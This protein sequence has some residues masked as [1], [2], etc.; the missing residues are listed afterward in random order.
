MVD[1]GDVAKFIFCLGGLNPLC[2][3]DCTSNDENRS[4]QPLLP[5]DS[6]YDS[7]EGVAEVIDS[8]TGYS[9]DVPRLDAD[10]ADTFISDSS[11]AYEVIDVGPK[12]DE[13]SAPDAVV[14]EDTY[15]PPQPP[16][17]YTCRVNAEDAMGV[18]FGAYLMSYEDVTETSNGWAGG[19]TIAFSEGTNLE[20][21]NIE[22]IAI[23]KA[24]SWG[25]GFVESLPPT[26]ADDLVAEYS[27]AFSEGSPGFLSIENFNAAGENST[28]TL[29]PMTFANKYS[30]EPQPMSSDLSNVVYIATNPDLYEI[31][32]GQGAG[33]YN[34]NGA[35][36]YGDNGW[37]ETVAG[38]DNVMSIEVY[39]Y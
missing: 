19:M 36:Y 38:W 31:P 3:P 17:T 27:V 32:S 12:P 25:E 22:T 24:D 1:A 10:V 4:F 15:Q 18:V 20:A 2:W 5:T 28:M 16:K 33:S 39:C 6:G 9:L 34:I 29:F 11:T 35:V 14:E 23:E 8:D 37:P 21:T 13:N 26:F 30:G 7:S